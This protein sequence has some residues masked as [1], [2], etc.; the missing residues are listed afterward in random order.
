MIILLRSFASLH[1]HS[2]LNGCFPFFLYN[3]FI[4]FGMGNLRIR[5]AS[6]HVLSREWA[7]LDTAWMAK[8]VKLVLMRRRWPLVGRLPEQKVWGLE[9]G[10]TFIKNNPRGSTSTPAHHF[11]SF[12]IIRIPKQRYFPQKMKETSQYPPPISPALHSSS[13]H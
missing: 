3:V 10:P 1:R 6:V 12:S 5:G 11:P 7:H 8:L 9:I 2:T 13:S 4:I